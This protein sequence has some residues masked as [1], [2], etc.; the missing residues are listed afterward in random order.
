MPFVEEGAE[1]PT[2]NKYNIVLKLPK[3]SLSGC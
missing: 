3:D 2:P 1:E